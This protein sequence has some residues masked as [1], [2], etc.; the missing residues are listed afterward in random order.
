MDPISI[1]LSLTVYALNARARVRYASKSKSR[2]PTKAVRYIR[3][4]IS[5]RWTI[6][7]AQNLISLYTELSESI[8]AFYEYML[9]MEGHVHMANIGI[10]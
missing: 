7:S 10:R 2:D 8:Y 9:N 6:L 1:T 4:P 3:T 5:P